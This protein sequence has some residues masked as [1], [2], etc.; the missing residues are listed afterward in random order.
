MPAY[1]TQVELEERYGL[2]LL[3]MLT[4]RAELATGV[5]D[6]DVVDRAISE[7]GAL[8]DG[9]VGGKYVLPF[10]AVPD[11]IASIAR[12]I[13]I[14]ELHVQTPDAK[15]AGEYD[16]AVALL[17]DIARGNIKLDAAGVS[18]A[19]TDAGGVQVTDRERPMTEANMKG[20]I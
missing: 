18:P 5:V 7:A 6:A 11:L 14:Y 15:I 13:A 2:E 4:D 17:R 16:G 8:I 19:Q 1:T 9:Y 10:A 3:I 12:K 20:F